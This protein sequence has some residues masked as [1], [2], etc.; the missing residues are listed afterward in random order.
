MVC[1]EIF[2]AAGGLAGIILIMSGRPKVALFNSIISF[3][4]ILSL[5]YLLIP[6]YGILGAAISYSITIVLINVLRITELYYFEKIQ[7]FKLSYVKPIIAGAL[8][9]LLM[10]FVIHQFNGALYMELIVG[11]VFYLAL[12]FG[13]I[14]ALRLDGE[15]KYLIEIFFGKLKKSRK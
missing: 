2:N 13:M 3:I 1:G 10:F 7:P 4:L 9:Y 14:W 15:D 11:S 6:I 12:F 5:S 8:V